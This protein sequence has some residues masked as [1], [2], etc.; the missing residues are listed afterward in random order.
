[1][2]MKSC[3]LGTCSL[4][5]LGAASLSASLIAY[6]GFDYVAGTGLDGQSGGTGWSGSWGAQPIV[7]LY[8]PSAPLSY[9]NGSVVVSGGST[10][11]NLLSNDATA[12]NRAFAAQTGTLYFSFLFRYD[13]NGSPGSLDVD[14]FVHFMLND[15]LE[16][17]SSGG[18]GLLSTGSASLG[19]RVG[20]SNGGDSTHSSIS[21]TADT[22]SLL[23][24]KLEKAGT[25][26]NYD[27]ISL[28][29]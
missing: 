19:A 4:W 16:N 22:T 11:V 26:G 29:V 5:G 18:I 17:H 28:F 14:D 25:S 9:N 13:D 3:L 10:G 23:V 21:M 7:E 15:D 1:M 24:G 27:R 8:T 12:T 2:N 6:D 20:T